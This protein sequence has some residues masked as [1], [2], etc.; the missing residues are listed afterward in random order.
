MCKDAVAPPF[1]QIRV[2][3]YI[4]LSEKRRKLL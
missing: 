4:F 2:Q 1:F 3:R